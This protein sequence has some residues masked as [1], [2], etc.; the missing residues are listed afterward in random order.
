[1]NTPSIFLCHSSDDKAVVRDL[2]RRLSDDGFAPW[3][4]EQDLLPGQD[5]EKE[6]TKAVRNSDI[7]LVCLSFS[8]VTK[9]GFMQKEIRCA[10]DAADRQPD[11]TIFFIPVRLQACEVPERLQRWQWVDLFEEKGYSRLLAS[12]QLRKHSL[13]QRIKSGPELFTLGTALQVGTAS[14]LDVGDSVITMTNTNSTG[15]LCVNAYIFSAAG[16]MVA[17][18]SCLVPPNSLRSFSSR[19]DLISNTLISGVPRSIIIKLVASSSITGTCN[20]SLVNPATVAPGLR[21][22]GQTDGSAEAPFSLVELSVAE[23]NSLTTGAGFILANGAGFGICRSC[24][25]GAIGA[26]P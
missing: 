8:S 18:C 12:L 13:M 15:S 7:V 25:A 26:G 1:V 23:L 9:A 5:W 2:Y 21:A 19:R 16:E 14:N 3:Q 11:G 6:I 10:L 20:P 22:W 17:C 4:D 24:H